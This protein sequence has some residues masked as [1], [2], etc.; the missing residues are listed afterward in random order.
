MN[1]RPAGSIQPSCWRCGALTP[2]SRVLPYTMGSVLSPYSEV[3]VDAWSMPRLCPSSCE[4]T[5]FR[6]QEKI[7]A[8]LGL[9]PSV[10]Y[11]AAQQELGGI[12]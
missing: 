8:P 6:S 7:H 4:Y 3:G 1:C 9:P 10:P 11:P 2:R 12:T 5:P